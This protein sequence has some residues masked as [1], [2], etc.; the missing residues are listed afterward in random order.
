MASYN[1]VPVS[2]IVGLQPIETVDTTQN[3]KLGLEVQAT[4]PTYGAATFKYCSGFAQGGTG[5]W[6]AINSDDGATSGVVANGV[7]NLIGIAMGALDATTKYGWVMIDGKH[8]AAKCLTGYADNGR[9]FLTS[10][11]GSVDDTSV[12]GDMVWNA[13]GA[14][15]TT[16]NTFVAEFELHRPFTTDKT[17]NT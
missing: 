13:K 10:T 9:V 16:A 14:S 3:H 17:A 1:Y 11:T 6:V 15:S 2:Q 12:A 5:K 4:D 8:P 7:N